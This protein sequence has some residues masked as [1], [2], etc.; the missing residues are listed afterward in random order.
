MNGAGNRTI[1]CVVRVVTTGTS[2]EA[3]L[4]A[5]R[6]I[7][8]QTGMNVCAA[9]S[10][11]VSGRFLFKGSNRAACTPEPALDAL[12]IGISMVRGGQY[13]Q[14]PNRPNQRF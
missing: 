2:A 11:V 6:I 3:R 5:F 10:S 12:A 9:S 13:R 4:R 8:V 7:P 1:D 14:K